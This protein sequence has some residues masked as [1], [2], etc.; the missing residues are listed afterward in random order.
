M[1]A[2]KPVILAVDDDVPV[3]RAVERDLRARY[4]RDYRIVAASSGGEALEA[5]RQLTVRGSAI[6]LFMVDQRMPLMTG[7]EFLAQ[8]IELQPDAKR[9]LLT[10]Y[11]DTDVAIRAINDIQLDHY[12]LKPWD[13]P[14]EKLYPVT[15]DLLEDWSA[16]FRPA[17]EGLRL[18]AG[19]WAPRGH[20]IRDFLT[21]NQVPYAWLDPEA[22]EEGRRLV[23]SLT[24]TETGAE[25]DPAIPIV[26]FPDGSS[27]RDPTTREIAEKV[28]LQT[29][30]AL[31]FYDLLIVGGGPAGLAAAVYGASEGLK[32]LLIEREA[33][34]G[35]AGTTSR[36]ENYLGF[37]A[38]LTGGDL[39]R[40]ALAQARRLGAEILSPQEV[41]GIRREDPYR[42]V[43]LADESEISC[44]T[45]V[46][47]TGVSYRQLGL[48]KA[49]ELA[50]AGI[51]YGAATTEAVLYRDADVGV[52]GGAN[53][54]GQAAVYLSRFAHRVLLIVRS[55]D[56]DGM[57]QYLI[58]QIAAIPNIEVRLSSSVTEVRGEGHLTGASVAGPEGSEELDLA[59]LFVFIG[60]QPRTEWLEGTVLRDPGGFIL[61]GPTLADGGK[62]PAGWGLNRE[63]FLLESSLPG[64]FCAGDVRHRSV[65]RIASAVGEGAMA[66]QFV[67]QYLAGL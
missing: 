57:S 33:P 59:A 67:H 44:Q 66:I 22:D 54:A 24:E 46:V 62:P 26:I 58:E 27:L 55:G 5:V 6:G 35:Q 40:R 4:G 48:P 60:Q 14:E 8:A 34:G 3:L 53:S 9:V 45:V 23:A 20:E 47:A 37:P 15:D 16:T 7:I 28:G 2:L 18:L 29:R 51:Y 43:A 10:A 61:T 30:A 25:L 49:A 1:A 63:P 21:R 32:T 39:A 19:R 12:I 50:G 56:L 41:S 65:K 52:I 31:P 64:V 17:F 42:V 38:G 13:P 11:A 36:I